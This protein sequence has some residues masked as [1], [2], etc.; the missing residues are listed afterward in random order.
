M[1]TKK[2]KRVKT[3]KVDEKIK[4]ISRAVIDQIQNGFIVRSF[5]QDGQTG[6]LVVSHRDEGTEGEQN[7]LMEALYHVKSI[8][9]P[10]TSRY[11]QARVHIC[12]YPGDKSDLVVECPIC[13]HL[14]EQ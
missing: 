12:T 7:A 14:P 6:V 2:V 1:N 10:G 3:D 5:D 4:F 13:G 11:D 8:V 9:D